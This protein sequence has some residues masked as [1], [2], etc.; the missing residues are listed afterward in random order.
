MYKKTS[1]YTELEVLEKFTI[2][3]YNGYK[4]K[5]MI[6]TIRYNDTE[7]INIEYCFKNK[8]EYDKFYR[9]VR[10]L[11]NETEINGG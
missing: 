5:R 3:A 10:K 9:Q 4:Q 11:M 8:S 6:V 2:V 1:I 7:N